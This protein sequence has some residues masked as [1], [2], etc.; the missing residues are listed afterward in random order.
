MWAKTAYYVSKKTFSLIVSEYIFSLITILGFLAQSF[1]LLANLFGRVVEVASFVSGRIF[2]EK[3]FPWRKFLFT[4]IFLDPW[5]K[6]FRVLA[7]FVRQK[8]QP[9][10]PEEHC[11]EK[12]SAKFVQRLISF[13]SV[14]HIWLEK[15]CA[16]E[17]NGFVVKL[18]F[19]RVQKNFF[20]KKVRIKKFS[21]FQ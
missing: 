8:K 16:S 15:S 5:W 9:L 11:E 7:D 20:R 12:Q 6:I 4:W 3:N 14:L 1:R 2:W 18:L 13:M 19:L 17:K 10:R 21:F